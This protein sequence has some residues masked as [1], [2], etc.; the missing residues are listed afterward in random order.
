MGNMTSKNNVKVL[1]FNAKYAVGA[2][3]CES[4]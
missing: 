1:S 2:Y 4:V 3:E